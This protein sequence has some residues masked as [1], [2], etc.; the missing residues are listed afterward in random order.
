VAAYA[1]DGTEVM[2]ESA[3]KWPVAGLVK[4]RGGVWISPLAGTS[5]DSVRSRTITHA[6]RMGYDTRTVETATI[7][8]ATIRPV[9][10]YF[11]THKVMIVQYFVPGQGDVE[12]K[13]PASRANIRRLLREGALQVSF[14]R[15]GQNG[16][17]DFQ[18]SELEKALKE[19]ITS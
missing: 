3:A 19:R 17:A 11:G 2:W 12:C 9:R 6:Y 8:D 5:Y 18:A 7:W 1:S 10:E 16:F 14:K 4:N 15:P 13:M